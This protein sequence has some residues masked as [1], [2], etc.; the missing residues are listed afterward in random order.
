MIVNCNIFIILI[1]Y[2]RHGHSVFVF[3]I[4]NE[5]HY[6]F[7]DWGKGVHKNNNKYFALLSHLTETKDLSRTPRHGVKTID[8]R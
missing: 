1:E 3:W 2:F 8:H 4:N 7:T 6:M 5:W